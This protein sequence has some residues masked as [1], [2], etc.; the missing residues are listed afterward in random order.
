MEI[1]EKIKKEIVSEENI[2]PFLIE[3]ITSKG[4]VN[5]HDFLLTLIKDGYLSRKKWGKKLGDMY[6]YAYLPINETYIDDSLIDSIPHELAERYSAFPV[7]KFGNS[8][9]FSVSAPLN[10]K[11]KEQ[12]SQLVGHEIS[13]VFSFDDEIQKAIQIYYVAENTIEALI[14]QVQQDNKFASESTSDLL[15]LAENNN[16][17]ELSESI[18]LMALKE[19]ASDVHIET[20]NQNVLIRLRKD[21]LLFDR[22]FLPKQISLPLVSCFKVMSRLDIAVRKRPQDG[23]LTFKLKSESIDIRISVLPT[24]Q[25]EKVVLRLLGANFVETH[26]GFDELGFSQETIKYIKRALAAPNGMLFVTGPTGSGKTTTLHCALNHL[27]NNERNIVSIEDPVEYEQP[28][29]TQCS[30]DE[31]SGRTFSTVLRAVMRQDPDV[32]M[33][34][35]IRDL[36]TAQIAANAALTGHMV[37]TSLHTNDTVQAMTRMIDMGVEHFVIAPSV[38]GVLGQRL[39]RKLCT[40]CKEIYKPDRDYFSQFFDMTGVEN[41]PSISKGVGCR[42][43]DHTGFKGR[44]PVHEFLGITADLRSCIL[45]SGN[46][47]Q[48]YRAAMKSKYYMPFVYDGIKKVLLGYTTIEEIMRSFTLFEE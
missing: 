14:S 33:V 44:I 25:G 30:I 36:E 38:I 16:V 21:G 40:N 10:N 28:N 15:R 9:T 31:K 3:N 2:N 19:K 37:L 7:Y 22:L 18:I 35:E 4:K 39:V 45:R 13:I 47:D 8:I 5:E 23:R 12:I 46:Q 43:C 41:L 42:Y 6:G 32:I 24:I 20:N 11:L 48:F 27:C 1:L 26:L 17:K 29:I 34:G